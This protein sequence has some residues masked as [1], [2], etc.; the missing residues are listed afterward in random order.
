MQFCKEGSMTLKTST[1][2]KSIPAWL[3]ASL[4]LT[5]LL[6]FY[7]LNFRYRVESRNKAVGVVV[8]LDVIKQLAASEGIEPIEALPLLKKR[9]VSGVVISEETIAT[10]ESE[11]KVSI[12]NGFLLIH[13]DPERVV[14]TL[15]TFFP[16]LKPEKELILGAIPVPIGNVPVSSIRQATVGLNPRDVDA[17]K[18]LGMYI[19]S[20]LGNPES[21]SGEAP[22]RSLEWAIDQGAEFLLPMGEQVIGRRG[23]TPQVIE[24]LK[25]KNFLYASAEFAKIGGDAAIVEALPEQ[26]IR[27]H[28]AQNAELDK[29]SVSAF[30]ERYAKAA[31]ER[32][33]RLLLLRPITKVSERPLDEF[34]SLAQKLSQQLKKEGYATGKPHAFQSPEVPSWLF[35]LIGLSLVPIFVWLGS[36][37][38]PIAAVLPLAILVGAATYVPA[39]RQIAALLAAGGLPLVAFIILDRI[40]WKNILAPY[41]GVSAVSLVGGLVVSGLLNGLPFFVK[42]DV[43]SGVK[44]AHFLPIGIIFLYFLASY[45]PLNLTVKKSIRWIDLIAGFGILVVIAFMASRTGNDGPAGVSGLELQFR[46]LLENVFPVRPRTKEFMIGHPMMIVAIGTMI[47]AKSKGQLES[48]G[49]VIALLMMGG[50]IGQTSIVNTLCHLHTPII[51]GLT[52]ILV[53][54]VLGGII[55]SFLWGGIRLLM[56]R[57]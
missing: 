44:L 55:G 49:F 6:C 48:K 52:R 13:K 18:S 40:R 31:T 8:E 27:L 39:G 26:T 33:Q 46:A 29:M 24:K 32:N 22:L 28:T 47:W 36:H 57:K 56:R 16:G 7:S 25:E 21:A 12:A 45:T 10:L 9:G 34:G 15:S 1:P 2:P 17:V 41:V 23:L 38:L 42:A 50:A 43:F 11:G 14:R 3:W 53:G 20:R 54:W 4:A 30:V 51:V 37:V 5:A 35:L 19:V